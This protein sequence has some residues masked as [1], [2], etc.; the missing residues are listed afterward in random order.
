MDRDREFGEYVDARALVMRRTAYLLCGDWHRAE[1]IVQ[2]ALTKL[3]V[4]WPRVRRDGTVDAYARKVLV[5][6]AID[7][8][9]RGFLRREG[10]VA[11][12]PDVPVSSAAPDLDVRRALAALPLGQRTVVVLRYWED[13]S[14]AEVARLLGRTE[15]TVK[16]Q[17]AKGLAALRTLL[18]TPMFEEQR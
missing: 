15:G 2:T 3:Y 1:D 13:L 16:S 10:A 9:R 12:V 4:A 5:R 7:E 17:A 6:C 14:V 11:D 18:G 8:G